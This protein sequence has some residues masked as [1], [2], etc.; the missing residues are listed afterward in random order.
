MKVIFVTNIYKEEEKKEV[1][2][3]SKEIKALGFDDYKIYVNDGIKNN[4]GYAYGVNQGIK[5]GLEEDGELFVV[6]NADISI[7]GLT[8]K[9][10]IEGLKKY[11]IFGFTVNQC[12]KTYY[13]GEIDRWRLSGGMIEQKPKKRYQSADFV[14][15]SLMFIKRAVV[16]RIGF[17]DESYFFYYD[18]TDYCLR[19]KKAG[20]KI[21]IDSQSCYQHF[22]L[23]ENNPRKGYF[24]AK[25]RWRFFW[26]NSNNIQKI[27]EIV[28]LPKT[29]IEY[30]P[31]LKNVFL[32]SRFMTNFFSLN[33]SSILNKFFHFFLFIFL[34]KNLSPE[35]YGIY[36]IVWAFIALFN[37]FVDLGTTTYGLV[38]LPK[39]REKM[40]NTLISLRFFIATLVFL[41]V[42]LSA[43]LFF[44]SQK[45]IIL[46]IFLTSM[47][48]ISG[49]WSGSY[50]IINSIKE[51]IINSSIVSLIF[52]FLF[53]ALIIIGLL[54]K[55][56][57]LTIFL[58]IFCLFIFY[59]LINFILVKNE[60]AKLR[61]CV[62]LVNWKKVISKSY[63]FILIGFL[64]GF[65]FK[66]DVFLLKFL[67]SEREVGIYNSGYKFLDA[68][69][70]LAASYNITVLPI[71]S[72]I[73]KD[74]N[75]LRRKIFKDFLMLAFVGV[76]IVIAFYFLA[77]MLLPL[78]LKKTYSGGIIT[79]RI[80]TFSLPFILVSSIF[81]NILYVFDLAR[82]VIFILLIQ[83]I[84]NII[85]NLIYI[86]T[87]S[88]IASAYITVISEVIN[89]ALIWYFARKKL[90]S[91]ENRH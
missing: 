62:D 18:E 65:Y 70:L 9:V 84:I 78:I 46:Y 19:A 33:L 28:R 6:F 15:G 40:I 72:R 90:M 36:T 8:K 80:V 31:L 85:L 71:M 51:K 77:P 20:F 86:P 54:I 30:L 37:P 39:N 12:S 52:N 27:Y 81:Y 60:V 61:I 35:K 58:I 64:S 73:K 14:S 76:S 2:R 79:A 10:I 87:Y 7:S 45:E 13:S 42:N 3:V 25:N 21:G 83:S 5:K 68:F 44:K 91:Y 49:I 53:V 41:M 43:F 24:L 88:Y 22:E 63:L 67:K 57:L 89:F 48:I 69:M 17:W 11:N 59:T 66:I 74:L 23:S 29:A 38:Y 47:T 50:L 26:R 4:R 75:L 1:N 34:V 32:Q 16:E 82:T 55:K 56:S